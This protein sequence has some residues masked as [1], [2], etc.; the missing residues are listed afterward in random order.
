[1]NNLKKKD[2]VYYARIMPSLGIY[3]ICELKVRTI[4]DTYF[5]GVD[6]RDKHAYIFN[7]NSINKVIF[8]D[9]KDALKLVKE[10]EKNRK[11]VISEEIYYEE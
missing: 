10:A 11:H 5:V 8:I 3:D 7:N 1:M 6:K 2:M 9:R 4:T